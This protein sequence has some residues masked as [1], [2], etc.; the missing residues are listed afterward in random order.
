MSVALKSLTVDRVIFAV[1]LTLAAVSGIHL[2]EEVCCAFNGCIKYFLKN[3]LL[4]SQTSHP[5]CNDIHNAHKPK[6]CLHVG[7]KRLAS[8]AVKSGGI[9]P[10]LSKEFAAPICRPRKI[11]TRLKD[12]TSQTTAVFL[13]TAV[14]T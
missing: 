3:I 8:E 4:P 13:V 9:L 12:A 5:S 2:L 7:P 10:N 11:S 1:G 14:R 6:K